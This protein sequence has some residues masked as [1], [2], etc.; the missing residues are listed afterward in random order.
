[1]FIWKHLSKEND[2]N[3]ILKKQKKDKNKIHI[4]FVSLWENRGMNL[5]S[6]IENKYKDS[7]R[8]VPIYV[9][10]SFN[11]PHSFVIYDVQN[12]PCLVTLDGDKVEKEEW[13]SMMEKRLKL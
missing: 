7:K 8:G 9:V 11:M 4:L 3:K 1:M 10:D 5:V 12:T 2:L 13:I 6:E